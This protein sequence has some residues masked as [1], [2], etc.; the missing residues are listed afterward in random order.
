MKPANEPH[1]HEIIDD[2]EG[3]EFGYGPGLFEPGIANNEGQTYPQDDFG[4]NLF[5]RTPNIGGSED[6]YAQAVADRR[7]DT[8]DAESNRD[9][10]SL[11]NPDRYGAQPPLVRAKTQRNINRRKEIEPSELK[12]KW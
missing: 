8:T 1:S 10:E 9:F 3:T 7:T 5:P 4:D 11:G 6:A 2:D 12:R